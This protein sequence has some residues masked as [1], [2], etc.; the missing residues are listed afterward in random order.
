M[1]VYLVK[2][3]GYRYDFTQKGQRATGSWFKTKKEA[4]SAEAKRREELKNP[5]AVEEAPTDMGLFD[6]VNTRLDDMKQTGT[7][8]H[9]NDTRYM[10]RRWVKEW[11]NTPSEQITPGMVRKFV[12]NRAKV[13]NQTANKEIR[14]LRATFNYGLNMKLTKNNPANGMKFLPV[15]KTVK[16]VPPPENLDKVIAVADQ[17]TQDYL[18]CLRDTMARKGEIDKLVWKDVDLKNGTITLYTRKKEG[19]SLTPRVVALT[20]RLL[21][22]LTRRFKQ[23]DSSKPWVFWH[24][25]WSSKAE[26]M[27]DGPYQDRKKIMKTLC[28]KAGVEYFRFH[29]IRHSGASVLD[30]KRVPIGAIQKILGHENRK[31]TEIY[32]HSMN[33]DEVDAIRVFEEA[34]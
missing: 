24:R 8:T 20:Q 28:K 29:P 21:V 25:Y 23:R 26:K 6:L 3:K 18:W 32:L 31:T 17:D 19:G 4:N 2:G 5:V 16:Y 14:Y 22:T 7:D 15:E 1:S 30:S 33:N 34:T 11:D 12:L 9:Y 10:A 27:V 13:S